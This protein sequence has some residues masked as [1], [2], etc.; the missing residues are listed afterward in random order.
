VAVKQILAQKLLVIV[1]CKV[2][3]YAVQIAAVKMMFAKTQNIKV[4]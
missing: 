4:N 1:K 2:L 3:A